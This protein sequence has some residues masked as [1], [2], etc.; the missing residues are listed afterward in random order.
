VL[1]LLLA[2]QLTGE[3]IEERGPQELERVRLCVQYWGS[4]TVYSLAPDHGDWVQP[5]RRGDRTIRKR[6]CGEVPKAGGL[7]VVHHRTHLLSNRS[8]TFVETQ[9]CRLWH[10]FIVVP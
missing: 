4:A 9:D 6:V 10:Y 1:W 3:K 5:P 8:Y 2:V 7:C